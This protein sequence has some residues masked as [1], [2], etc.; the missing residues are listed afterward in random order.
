MNKVRDGCFAFALVYMTFGCD[1]SETCETYA[2]DFVDSD[3][4]GW[5]ATLNINLVAALVGARLAARAM[6]SS[7][8]P[9]GWLWLAKIRARSACTAYLTR[10]VIAG[11]ILFM[12]SAG[13]LFPVRCRIG[14]VIQ[15][16]CL[17]ERE[18]PRA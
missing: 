9:G 12:A 4:P 18:F 10:T 16:V 14:G 13:G 15:I 7:G 5:K 6:T 1:W 2:G 17:I 11:A 8:K 3:G